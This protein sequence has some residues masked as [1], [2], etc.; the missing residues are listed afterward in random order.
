MWLDRIRLYDVRCVADAE[1]ELD[2]R[3]NVL[4]GANGAGKT[5]VLEAAHL[6]S[7]G[8][9]FRRGPRTHL[10]R[11][12]ARALAVYAEI[13]HGAEHYERIGMRLPLE[14]GRWEAHL[15]GETAARLSDVLQRCAVCCFEPGSH[16]LIAGPAELRREF[17]D[18]TL[19]HV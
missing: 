8:R 7:F 14:T 11:R 12:G 16:A 1:L 17:L 19:F 3:L 15:D 13:R 6:L 2:P 18:W 4:I 10:I 5:T 9:S